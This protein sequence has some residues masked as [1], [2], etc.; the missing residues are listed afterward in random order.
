MKTLKTLLIALILT[1]AYLY[2]IM[3]VKGVVIANLRI[4]DILFSVAYKHRTL[5]KDIIDNIVLVT[6]DDES[7]KNMDMKWPWQRGVMAGMVKS[8]SECGPRAIFLD[9]MFI[10]KSVDESQ[11]LILAKALM[12]AGNVFAGAYFG[13]DNRFVTPEETIAGSL[14]D[15]GFVDK[16]RDVDDF[17]RRTRPYTIVNPDNSR[18]Y[19][20][21]LKLASFITGKAPEDILRNIPGFDNC[22]LHI[23]YYGNIDKF[24]TIPAW[25]LFDTDKKSIA[26]LIKDKIVFVGTTS[27][28][29]HDTHYTRMGLMSG[30]VILM[31]ETAG[32]IRN[33][34]LHAAGPGVNFVI[35]LAF[36]F[37]AILAEK[38]L[39]I[40]HGIAFGVLEFALFFAVSVTA[41]L[42]NLILDYFGV[43]LLV[44]S[45]ALFFYA[46][47][48]LLMII[49]NEAL[50]KEAITD[51]LTALY[52]YRYFELCL[53]KELKKAL[54]NR[55]RIAM[56]FYDIDHFKNVND[57]YGHEFGNMVLVRVAKALKDNTRSSNTLARYGGEEFCVLL[58]DT[59]TE[60][61]VT[62]AENI[63]KVI[64]SLEFKTD[65]GEAVKITI[66]GGIVTAENNKDITGHTDFIKA[67]DKALYRS[68]HTGRDRISVYDK[69]LDG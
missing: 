53:K 55:G 34:F 3:P 37:A 26:G 44:V 27:E 15:F 28:L 61:T 5:P 43:P 66:S 19:C 24:K 14:K 18:Q 45:S 25:K 47:K 62:Y 11:D 29:I 69:S 65:K 59:S 8:I 12:D 58:A 67:A 17:I 36:V 46:R 21:T 52:L 49:E 64:K 51:G 30:V 68:K 2:F 4:S 9:L 63:R 32:Y 41:F 23:N 54:D 40:L 20:L 7:F 13:S 1:A 42:H 57:T 60:N 50:K 10:G 33:D 16:P 22:N 31:N 38:R 39:Q 6:I 35:I 56:V 48:H